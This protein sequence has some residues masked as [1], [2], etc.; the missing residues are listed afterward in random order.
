[1]KKVALMTVLALVLCTAIAPLL[2]NEGE[3]TMMKGKGHDV[4]VEVI[5]VDMKANTMT[6]KGENGEPKTVPVMGSAV[7]ELPN[8]KGGE[9]I[10]VTCW[11]N[12]KGEH[13]GITHI[14]TAM[15]KAEKK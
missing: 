6:V 14:K 5:S 11:D 9:K 12:D 7:K 10:T 15:A 13:Q 2:A 1:M 3:K 4:T 8:V